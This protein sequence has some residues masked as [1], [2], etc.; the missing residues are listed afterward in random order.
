MCSYIIFSNQT[1]IRN[2]CKFLGLLYFA[3]D[4]QDAQVAH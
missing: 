3:Q 2:Y 1:A 4:A